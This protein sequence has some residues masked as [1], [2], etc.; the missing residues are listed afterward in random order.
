MSRRERAGEIMALTS[1]W[2]AVIYF[3]WQ[4]PGQ[5]RPAFI[6]GM[7]FAVTLYYIVEGAEK[8]IRKHF[9]WEITL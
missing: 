5:G 7:V 3:W 1:G 2:M 6:L 9:K 8:R 4:A